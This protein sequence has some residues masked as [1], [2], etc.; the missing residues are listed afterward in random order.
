MEPLPSDQGRLEWFCPLLP[1]SQDQNLV[2]TVLYVPHSLD[3]LSSGCVVG[4]TPSPPS[5]ICSR[6]PEMYLNLP[7]DNPG[8]NIKSISHRCYPIL[9]PCAWELNKETI[10]LPLSCLQG[11]VPTTRPCH[12]VDYQGFLASHSG[13]YVPKQISHT[14]SKSNAYE[15]VTCGERPI[16]HRVVCTPA[17]LCL[18]NPSRL[19]KIS[20]QRRES[21]LNL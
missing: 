13:G 7:E 6:G 14:A 18:R 17:K 12:S 11:G 21:F 20:S 19:S 3:A 4:N 2:W 8:A 9:V 15:K 10:N 1:E 5:R 16:V